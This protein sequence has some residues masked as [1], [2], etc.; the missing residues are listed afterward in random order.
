MKNN[1]YE[2]IIPSYNGRSLLQKHLPDVVSFSGKNAQITVID[3]GGNDETADLLEKKFP[4]IKVIHNP[5]NLGFTKSVNIGFKNARS[6]LVV[7][8]N[9]DVSPTE[10][11]LLPALK[12]FNNG[13]V[14]AVTFNE[15]TS[16]W[17]EVSFSGKLQYVRGADKSVARYSA[18]ASGG[19][20]IFRRSIWNNLD[21]FDEVYSPGYWE[22][23]DIGWRAWK[24]GY[25]IIWEPASVVIHQHE[26]TFNLFKKSYLDSLKQRNELIFNWKNITDLKL[27][28]QHLF[29]L[30]KHSLVHPGYL[31]IVVSAIAKSVATK[32]I[33]G[34]LTDNQ[35]LSLVN[36]IATYD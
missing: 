21:G 4:K 15:T 32:K 28:V 29:F 3:D 9:N 23:I 11:Y 7:L 13:S 31:R 6:D 25:K 24:A 8:L 36:K 19:S 14:F 30:L 18:W 20:A 35:V 2:I 1:S 5:R 34:D 17:P 16:S 12:Y 27:R 22:D 10:G 33:P 26:N